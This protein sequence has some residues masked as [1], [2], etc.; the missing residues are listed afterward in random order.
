[1]L[2]DIAAKI[3]QLGRCHGYLAFSRYREMGKDHINT[4]LL[5]R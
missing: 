3:I 5:V 4:D 1:M 2:N